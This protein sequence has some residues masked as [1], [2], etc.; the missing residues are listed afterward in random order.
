[1][2]CCKLDCQ[3]TCCS[4]WA[5][6]CSPVEPVVWRFLPYPARAPAA[7]AWLLE[8]LVRSN[9]TKGRRAFHAPSSVGNQSQ[10]SPTLRDGGV[11]VRLS[12]PP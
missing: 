8:I 10:P 2:F 3:A 6:C 11:E 4:L 5:R 12:P 7:A 9:T 1:M